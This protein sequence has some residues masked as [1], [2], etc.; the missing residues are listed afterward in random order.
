MHY[1]FCTKGDAPSRTVAPNKNIC[2]TQDVSY[3]SCMTNHMP[4][5]QQD[6]ATFPALLLLSLLL[7]DACST[8]TQSRSV[9]TV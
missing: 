1:S 4:P 8:C 7:V 2:R 3:L 9:L 6:Q 5:P